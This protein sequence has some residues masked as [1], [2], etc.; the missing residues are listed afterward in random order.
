ME[1]KMIAFRT[2]V[3]TANDLADNNG[4]PIYNLPYFCMRGNGVFDSQM[5]LFTENTDVKAFRQ[6]YARGQIYVLEDSEQK[7]VVPFNCDSCNKVI[8]VNNKS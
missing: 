2:R 1:V 6:L 5:Y 8:E 3:A 7:G 4:N